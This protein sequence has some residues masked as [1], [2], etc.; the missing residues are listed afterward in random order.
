MP[1]AVHQFCSQVT[2]SVVEMERTALQEATKIRMS[3]ILAE[4]SVSGSLM[5]VWMSRTTAWS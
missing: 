2:M 3:V 1:C 4:N 5:S